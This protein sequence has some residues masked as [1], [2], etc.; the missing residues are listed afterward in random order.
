MAR[1]A[2]NP[3]WSTAAITSAVMRAVPCVM[4]MAVLS[5]HGVALA[6]GDIR[7]YLGEFNKTGHKQGVH[8]FNPHTHTHTR[9]TTKADFACAL[10]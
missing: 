6:S 9:W 5:R 1:F 10:K 3:L 2:V 8:K 4:L 7:L